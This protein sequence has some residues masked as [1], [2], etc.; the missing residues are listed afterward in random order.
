VYSRVFLLPSGRYLNPDLFFPPVFPPFF[1]TPFLRLPV[2][3]PR[4]VF[5]ATTPKPQTVCVF[6]PFGREG[7]PLPRVKI[8][9]FRPERF[10]GGN[11]SLYRKVT[12]TCRQPK[13][14]GALI[15]PPP[16]PFSVSGTTIGPLVIRDLPSLVA[17]VCRIGVSG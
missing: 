8:F 12:P 10:L 11:S 5:P 2:S 16:P 1:P 9:V 13:E 3:R 6:F 17:R 4:G 14:R 15:F 7:R